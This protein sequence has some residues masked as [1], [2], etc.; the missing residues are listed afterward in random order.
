MLPSLINGDTSRYYA[1]LQAISEPTPVQRD[2]YK[3]ETQTAAHTCMS[4][5]AGTGQT[6]GL[7][8]VLAGSGEK[9]SAA[10]NV[11]TQAGLAGL[12]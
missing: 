4:L 10:L 8:V 2:R 7:W 1:G 6:E 12:S 3:C 11:W 5:P 9:S